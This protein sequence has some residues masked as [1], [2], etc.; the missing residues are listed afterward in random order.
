[1]IVNRVLLPW[2]IKFIKRVAQEKAF[3]P[4]QCFWDHISNIAA[5]LCPGQ[6]P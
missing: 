3:L 6:T 5:I 1:M 2:E 4:W